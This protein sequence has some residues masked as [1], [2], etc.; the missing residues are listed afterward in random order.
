MFVVSP[1][2]HRIDIVATKI[3]AFQPG[4]S[5]ILSNKRKVK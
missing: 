1:I 3:A 5:S 2:I 4:V